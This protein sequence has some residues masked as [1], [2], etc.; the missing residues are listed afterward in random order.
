MT[1]KLNNRMIN[2]PRYLIHG[3]D[4]SK[5]G[6]TSI[7]K[8]M[9]KRSDRQEYAGALCYLTARGNARQN[10]YHNDDDKSEY[11]RS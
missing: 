8:G 5:P 11:L 9:M 4:L 2:N 1:A 6:Y 3:Y 10:I 7:S